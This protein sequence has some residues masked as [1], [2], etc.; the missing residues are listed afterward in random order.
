MNKK[1]KIFALLA[2]KIFGSTEGHFLF[3]L[4]LLFKSDIRNTGNYLTVWQLFIEML[5]Q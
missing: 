4:N 3:K 2:L 5:S 1:T